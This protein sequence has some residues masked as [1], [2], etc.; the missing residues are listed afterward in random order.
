MVLMWSSL[1]R[2]EGFAHLAVEVAAVD[3]LHAAFAVGGFL[4]RAGGKRKRA[5]GRT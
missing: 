3:E 2:A 5:R 4:G 1:I